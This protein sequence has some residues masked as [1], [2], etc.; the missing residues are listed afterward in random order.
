VP[1]RVDSRRCDIRGSAVAVDDDHPPRAERP[2]RRR[3]P[4]PGAAEEIR[5]RCRNDSRLRW[6][7][8]VRVEPHQPVAAT[9]AVGD[10]A[11]LADENHLVNLDDFHLPRAAALRV[12][13]AVQV[14]PD[15]QVL[16]TLGFEIQVRDLRE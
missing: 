13:L 6:R 12:D 16:Q 5:S 8:V 15:E 2:A 3:E 1:G 10:V 7:L 14:V 11:V 9:D 4:V